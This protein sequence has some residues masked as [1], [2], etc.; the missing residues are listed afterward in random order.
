MR[1]ADGITD[2]ADRSQLAIF[3]W[4][5]GMTDNLPKE[6]FLG[7]SKMGTSQTTEMQ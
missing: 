2:K 3:V 4:F 1:L 5:V 7:I 6:K